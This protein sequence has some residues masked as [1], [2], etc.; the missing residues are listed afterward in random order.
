MHT[1]FYTATA[2]CRSTQIAHDHV[3]KQIHPNVTV[4]KKEILFN[5]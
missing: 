3:Y 2:I 1:Q 4:K 5:N